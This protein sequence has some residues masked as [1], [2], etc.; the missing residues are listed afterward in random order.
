MQR[1]LSRPNRRLAARSDRST[2]GNPGASEVEH[3][4]GPGFDSR[5]YMVGFSKLAE[6]LR[7]ATPSWTARDGARAL[8]DAVRL[9]SLT[10]LSFETYTRPA[11]LK[12]RGDAGSLGDELRWSY[13][14]EPAGPARG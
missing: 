5:S 11:R 6:T 13:I 2:C 7:D 9:V 14:R 3:A 10:S 8:G 12:S 1:Y 4:K